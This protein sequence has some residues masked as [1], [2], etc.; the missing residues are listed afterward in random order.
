MEKE[1][2]DIVTGEETLPFIEEDR[3]AFE[4]QVRRAQTFINLSVTDGI[5]PYISDSVGPKE[6][7][8]T[9]KKLFETVNTSHILFLKTKLHTMWML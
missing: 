8:D 2:W 1:L 6:V 5:I 9:L 4:R 7:W 3:R